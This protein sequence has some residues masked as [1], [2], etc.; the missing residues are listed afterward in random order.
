ML[1]LT[2]VQGEYVTI[3]DNIILQYERT[4]GER[5]RLTINAPK[6]IPVIRGALLEK[7]G[8]KRPDCVYDIPHWFR[9]EISLDRSKLQA[10]R[11]MRRVLSKMDSENTDVQK[12]RRELDHIFPFPV[13]KPEEETKKEWIN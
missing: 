8:G 4:V 6:E 11:A 9:R 10:L 1:C 7:N 12:L 2:L 5:C 13:K 3:G